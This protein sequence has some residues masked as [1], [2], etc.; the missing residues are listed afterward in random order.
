MCHDGVER[1]RN[2]GGPRRGDIG[3][4]TS[5][6]KFDLRNPITHRD[7]DF[8]VEPSDY[9]LTSKRNRNVESIDPPPKVEGAALNN[10]I[11][12]NLRP[13]GDTPGDR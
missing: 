9:A 3:E 2:T 5:N 6:R 4:T 8:P 12:G 11:K 13:L 10:G 7:V 1:R